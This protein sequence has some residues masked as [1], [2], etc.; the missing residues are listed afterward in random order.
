MMRALAKFL[1]VIGFLA[2]SLPAFAVLPSEMLSDPKLEAR[3]RELSAQLRCLVCQNE[4]IDESGADLARDLR[5]LIREHISRGESNDE[6]KAFLV[7]RYG[8]FILLQPPFNGETLALWLSAP[9]L[10]GL[11]LIAIVIAVRRP[12]RQVTPL[13]EA[14]ERALAE[15]GRE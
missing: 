9:V 15:A 4:S 6:I 1:L 2:A 7:A 13:S 12:A 11:G 14:E 8:T 5:L 3:A 10:L